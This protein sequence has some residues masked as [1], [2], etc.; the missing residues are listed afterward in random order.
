MDENQEINRWSSYL[1]DPATAARLA[2]FFAQEIHLLEAVQ[3]KVAERTEP[4][5]GVIFPFLYSI[6]DSNRAFHLLATH[7]AM[8]GALRNGTYVL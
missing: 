4:F 2:V 5:W 1:G 7:Q 8:R 6:S 3:A